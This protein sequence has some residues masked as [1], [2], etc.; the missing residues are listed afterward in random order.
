MPTISIYYSLLSPKF[1]TLILDLPLQGMKKAELTCVEMAYLAVNHLS[2][3]LARNYHW[4]K[5]PADCCRYCLCVTGR[6]RV[7]MR[8]ILMLRVYVVK[9]SHNKVH[10]MNQLS[11]KLYVSWITTFSTV[12]AIPCLF[13]TSTSTRPVGI[14]LWPSHLCSFSLISNFYFVISVVLQFYQWWFYCVVV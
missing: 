14:H 6:M 8:K 4:A 9:L 10:S 5:P 13:S 11:V 2:T 7:M 1:Q 3:K 12:T